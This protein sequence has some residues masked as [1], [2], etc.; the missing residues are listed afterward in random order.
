MRIKNLESC[1]A[2]LGISVMVL[3]VGS[4]CCLAGTGHRVFQ[5]EI[6]KIRYGLSY[7]AAEIE[8][9]YEAVDD[10]AQGGSGAD[11]SNLKQKSP[12]KAFLLSLA[13]PGLG[14]LYYGSKIKPVL[15]VGA[16]AAGWILRANYSDEG[17]RLT[18]EFEAFN[19][20]HW[21]EGDYRD[22]LVLAYDTS[23]EDAITAKEISH[24]LPD[25]RTQQYYEMTGKY[26][27]FAWG[28]DDAV[29]D[30]NTLDDYRQTDTIQPITSDPV[31]PFSARRIAYEDMRGEANNKHRNADR[32]LA[33]LLVNHVA[34]AIEAFISTKRHNS[35]AGGGREE[36]GGWKVSPSL[37][38]IYSKYDT[39]YLKV[40][41]KF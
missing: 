6:Q 33:A 9:F 23:D 21:S 19:R 37:K 3:L 7:Q 10:I 14:Q 32:M 26:N 34:S 31:T 17:D 28:W 15:F 11:K 1:I 35:K 39:P 16:E 38:S 8:S 40:T 12:T 27:Q 20:A 13:V 5:D 29:L 36:F 24:H 4:Q 30:G 25:T 41:Y 2:F 18:E 22:Y